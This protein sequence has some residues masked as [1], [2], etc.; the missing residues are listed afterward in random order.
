M[1]RVLF[2]MESLGQGGA[3]KIIVDLC[4]HIDRSRFAATL[5]VVSEGG[6]NWEAALQSGVRLRCIFRRA[7][8]EATGLRGLRYRVRYHLLR[9]LPPRWAHRLFLR[10]RYNTEIAFTEGLA[11]RVVSGA[12]KRRRKLAWVHIDPLSDPHADPL[13]EDRAAQREAYRRFD[14]VLCVS[15]SVQTA[16]AQKFGALPA[17]GVQY[18]PVDAEAIRR[19]AAEPAPPWAAD[20]PA[21]GDC[22]LRLL[23]IAR[24]VIAKGVDR[25]LR[26]CA[27]LRA[28]QFV[29]T[30]LVLGEGSQR[31][32]LEE[33]IAA[34]GL[35]DCVRLAGFR[36]NPYPA[37]AQA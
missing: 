18:N 23:C 8:A 36:A 4:S 20:F 32:E 22:G 5:L 19:R 13:F 25:L 34:G 6:A 1:R 35:A 2:F 28:E 27:R 9:R 14:R 21:A 24:L 26:V 33:I 30:L 11:T 10:G 37:L 12:P 7:Q 15:G 3:E 29:F 16:F 17:L 31:G